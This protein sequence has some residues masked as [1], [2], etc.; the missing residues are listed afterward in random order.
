[1]GVPDLAGFTLKGNTGTSG[2]NTNKL[3][4]EEL[5][6]FRALTILEGIRLNYYCNTSHR[7]AD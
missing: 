5:D 6:T 1:M 4:P 7:R 3:T 2:E